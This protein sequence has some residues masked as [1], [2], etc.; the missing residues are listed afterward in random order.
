GGGAAQRPA[1]RGDH[2]GGQQ[3][4]GVHRGDVHQHGGHHPRQGHHRGTPPVRAE[5]ES[6][7]K[8]AAKA[9]PPGDAAL[10]PTDGTPAPPHAPAR[11]SRAAYPR[12]TR[13]VA[14]TMASSAASLPGQDAP[15][16]SAPQNTPNEVSMT[17]TANFMVFSGTRDSG[18]R[19]A[20]PTPATTTTATA[21]PA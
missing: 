19:T 13:A 5:H 16:P 15:A 6:V 8:T 18:A 14:G 9:Q 11:R 12:A 20:T 4:P 2:R 10:R 21:A 3:P 7:P 17:P 1:E